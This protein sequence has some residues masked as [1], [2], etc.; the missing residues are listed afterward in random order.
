MAK[1]LTADDNSILK[2]QA[3]RRL[4]GAVAL[5]TAVV[6]ILPLVFDAE[7]PETTL[8]N[9]ELR[10]PDKNKVEEIHP[11]AAA[12]EVIS[13]STEVAQVSTSEAASQIRELALVSVPAKIEVKSEAEPQLK[14]ASLPKAEA[15]KKNK[16]VIHVSPRT[17]FVVQVAALSNAS[18]AKAMQDKL[19]KQG[20]HAYTEKIGHNIRVRVGSYPTRKLAEDVRKKL[21]EFGYHPN[22]ITLVD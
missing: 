21:E 1:Q 19:S 22:V 18:S 20:L 3:R 8:N 15:K 9:I 2:Q 10:I 16:P 7:P 12:S 5:T 13:P 6:I 11:I 17:G 14:T 4:I